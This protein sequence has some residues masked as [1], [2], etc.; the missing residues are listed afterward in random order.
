MRSTYL[1]APRFILPLLMLAFGLLLAAQPVFAQSVPG[2]PTGLT[3]RAVGL[4][5]VE[6]SWTAPSGTVT[7]YKIEHSTNNGVEWT[8]SVASTETVN[9]ANGV[10]TYHSVTA[11]ALGATV[12]SNLYRVLAINSAGTGDPSSQV[13]VTLPVT[14]AQPGQPTAVM[15][16]AN[17]S[18]EINLTWSAPATTGSGDIKSYKIEYSKDGNLPWMDVGTT[19]VTTADKGTKYSNTGLAPATTR[20]YRVSAMNIAG[21]GPASDTP[22]LADGDEPN[23]NNT[24]H[25]A[26][27]A[28]AG[29]PA[30]PTGLTAVAVAATGANAVELSWTAPNE[31]RAP[32]TGYMIESFGDHDTDDTT[33]DS[34]SSETGNGGVADT[35]TVNTATG[36]QTYHAVTAAV[37][38]NVYRVSA[39]N[40]LGMG[41]V[42]ATVD[43]TPPVASE[44]PGAPGNTTTGVAA[45]PDGSTE[46]DVTWTEA[47]AGATA[48]TG[49]VIEYSKDNGLPW[50]QVAT[51]GGSVL[52]YSDTSLTPDT[53]RYYRVSAVNSVGRGPASATPEITGPANA[54]D[55][56][57]TDHVAKTDDR[58]PSSVPG[59]P[60]GLTARAVGL[61]TVEL[62]WT[63]PS[64]T[65]TDYKIEHSTNNGVEWTESVASTETVNTANGVQTYHSVTATA[66]GAT[67]TS[68]LYRVLAIN[69]A[70]TGD[71]SSQVSVTLPVTTAQPGQPTAVMAMANG[72]TEI[73]LTWSA[74]ATTGSGDI[75][76][77]KIEY[78]KDG[79]LP[80]MDV[81]TT[82]VTTADKGTKYSNTGLAPAT[83]RYYRVSAMNIAG[84]GP[85]SD[86]PAL[87]DGDEPNTN[88]TD[89]VAKT[90]LAGV[91]AAPTGLTAVAVAA[92]GANAVELSWTAPNEGRAPITG[93]M[94][95]SFGDHDTDDTTP[96]SWSSETG[97][98]GVA[99]TETVNTAT[100]VQTYHAVTAAVRKNVYRV[101][102]MNA[103][104]M[105]PVS[106]TVDV[107]PPV[108]SEE[109]GAPG[110]TTTGVA[111]RP[112]GSTEIDVTWTEAA[113]GATATTGYVIEY[114]KDNGLPWMQVA[115]VGGSVLRYSDTSL[116]PDTT[117][118]YRV[119]AVNSVGRG[120]ASATPEITGPAN[121]AD[122]THTDHVAK[123][124]MGPADQMGTV[125]LSTQAPM[126]GTAITATLTDADG[127][128][129]GQMWQWEKSM[130]KTSWMDATGAGAMTMSYTPAAMDV[131]YYLRAMVTYTDKN[132]SGR[133][134]SSMATEMMTVAATT[135]S[136]LLSRYDADES[137]HIDLTEVNMA[138][139]DYFNG[140]LTL[141]EVNKVIDLYFM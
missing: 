19:T 67:V 98:G 118:Y 89:H 78:S 93:Y 75:K 132:G 49:Y 66:L 131:G 43:V 31:G 133:T 76:S 82:T 107:T 36:V 60:T 50:M 21:R 104:G 139:D 103:L 74:P 13:S 110:N 95:E 91:P 51:V 70:G 102:A 99:D 138:I 46:I 16:M 108:A 96:D 33:P 100:G 123:T 10:Q 57:H 114:S 1:L 59:K 29:V 37:R 34:W 111:A 127:M 77:Y 130:N 45:R 87:A 42:S 7:D 141:D 69:S 25:V 117:R 125:T 24:D 54:A 17:G 22:A 5:T 2:K 48:T 18:T 109:P 124:D 11:T 20:Y 80:W 32:I 105:G 63:A 119:S 38:K 62:S 83:T 44:E 112:D 56:T 71:P 120:P 52:R 113:A 39:M 84:R 58:V 81:G 128:V 88:N 15:A 12:T 65:V 23:T 61:T 86:T 79:N 73:N 129:T 64:G 97:N 47:A 116:T 126:V 28:L 4:T 55:G 6:L 35:E 53:T 9:T 137:G 122:G 115:T 27:T 26:K 40:A 30:A 41:P 101:S 134:A 121:A 3:A 94:I 72:S 135:G 136:D 14:T 140:D 90:A 8:E 106:A 92:T 85:A 68:N